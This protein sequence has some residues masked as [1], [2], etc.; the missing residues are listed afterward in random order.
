MVAV[1]ADRRGF[2][3]GTPID[4]VSRVGPVERRAWERVAAHVLAALRLRRGLARASFAAPAG[5]EANA[6]DAV[7]ATNGKIEH[8]EG[9][10]RSADARRALRDAVVSLERARGRMRRS[11]PDDALEAW[12]ALVSGRWSVI[13]HFERGGR[14]YFIARENAPDVR[15]PRALSPRERQVAAY[16]ALG[17]TNKLI[18]YTLGLSTSTVASQVASAAAKLGVG[19]RVELV[20]VVRALHAQ[21]GAGQAVDDTDG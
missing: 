15:D 18:G 5:R 19:S 9:D 4:R 13:E 11:S 12:R 1:D 21:S 8:A 2:M 16:A 10:A 14:R 3:I 20:Q 17:H 6:T 7:I